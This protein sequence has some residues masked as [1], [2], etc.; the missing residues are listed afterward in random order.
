[1]QL[2][3]FYCRTGTEEECTERGVL[4]EEILKI[5]AQEDTAINKILNSDSVD[6]SHDV[7]TKASR[8]AQ[9]KAANTERDLIAEGN[10]AYFMFKQLRD[11]T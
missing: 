11:M 6:T 9:N 2:V 1:V 4:I 3:N 5:K 7:D 10:Q 8:Q